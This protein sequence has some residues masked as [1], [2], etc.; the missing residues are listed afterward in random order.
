[1]GKPGTCASPPRHRAGALV[2]EEPLQGHLCWVA[3]A[4]GIT[5]RLLLSPKLCSMGTFSDHWRIHEL[6][7]PLIQMHTVTCCQF[8]AIR[9]YKMVSLLGMLHVLRH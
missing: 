8:C 4:V 2:S 6:L 3:E 5:H 9:A 7:Q 1:M